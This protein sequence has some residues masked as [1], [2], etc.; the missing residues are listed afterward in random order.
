MKKLFF[1]LVLSSVILLSTYN[2]SVGFQVDSKGGHENITDEAARLKIRVHGGDLDFWNWLYTNDKALD[3]FKNGAHDEDSTIPFDIPLLFTTIKK[4]PLHGPNPSTGGWLFH[5][6]N[7][8]QAW[9]GEGCSLFQILEQR[10]LL[11]LQL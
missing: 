2:V 1:I 6:Y 4:D 7:P 10:L 5:F 11:L 9:G 8:A 3:S